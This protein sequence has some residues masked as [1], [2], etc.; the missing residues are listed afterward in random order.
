MLVFEENYFDVSMGSSAL[1]GDSVVLS[2]GVAVRT[3]VSGRHRKH[4]SSR[5]HPA[6][7]SRKTTSNMGTCADRNC[8]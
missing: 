6:V 4:L 2:R 5:H 1:G 7:K 3:D 8:N